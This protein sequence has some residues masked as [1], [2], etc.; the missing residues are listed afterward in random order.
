[1]NPKRSPHRANGEGKTNNAGPRLASDDGSVKSDGVLNFLTRRSL[2]Q[3]MAAFPHFFAGSG[4][5][6]EP[7]PVYADKTKPKC[8]RD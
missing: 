4:T 1:M 5:E 7:E 3:F 6:P 8:R 2:Q